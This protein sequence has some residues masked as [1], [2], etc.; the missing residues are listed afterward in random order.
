LLLRAEP[1]TRSAE[2]PP[3]RQTELPCASNR[4]LV[5]RS[6]MEPFPAALGARG[7]CRSEPPVTNR[8]TEQARSSA[9]SRRPGRRLL[10][11]ARKAHPEAAPGREEQLHSLCPASK[12]SF[13]P[14]ATRLEVTSV[15]M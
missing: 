10:A 11:T 7:A 5:H 12:A 14:A 4:V 3:A 8:R 6:V 9:H 1:G 15:I 13:S 2:A